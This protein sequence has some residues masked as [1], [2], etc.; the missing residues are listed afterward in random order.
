M[1][2]D[3][4]DSPGSNSFNRGAS[5]VNY[6]FATT[7]IYTL[8]VHAKYISRRGQ[9]SSLRERGQLLLSKALDVESP[10]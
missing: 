9:P 7:G 3:V 10:A 4:Y 1:V 5:T 6:T 2:A 8:L